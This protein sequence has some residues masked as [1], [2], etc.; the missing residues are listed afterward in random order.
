MAILT[1]MPA[2]RR[3]RLLLLGL[4]FGVT[5]QLEAQREP[6]APASEIKAAYLLNFARY[7]EWPA[8]TFSDAATPLVVCVVEVEPEPLV[9]SKA[10]GEA[11]L[12]LAEDRT[13]NGRPVRAVVVRSS[14]EPVACHIA[15][16]S[17]AATPGARFLV[18]SW[19]TRPVL[20]VGE[21]EK[22]LRRGGIVGFMLVQQTVRF[23][24]DQEAARRAGLRVSSRVLAL[25]V[26]R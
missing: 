20:T 9:E 23:A 19:S 4:V 25:A 21:G 17:A 24:I 22:F 14:D 3:P 7:V 8:P 26:P 2:G 16:F 6:G 10:I 12:R 15:Y 5:V 13:V 11:L 1:R 18:T